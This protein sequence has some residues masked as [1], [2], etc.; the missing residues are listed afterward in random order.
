MV[1]IYVG[2]LRCG[3]VS[4][5]NINLRREIK[6]RLGGERSDLIADWWR[7]L[8]S[9]FALTCWCGFYAKFSSMKI[10]LYALQQLCLWYICHASFGAL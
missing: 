6:R 3:F 9:F 4:V 5:F 10:E 2:Y 1:G 8:I 7:S